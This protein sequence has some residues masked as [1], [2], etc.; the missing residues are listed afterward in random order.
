MTQV[1]S[2]MCTRVKS[3][4]F[5]AKTGNFVAA[6]SQLLHTYI[7]LSRGDRETLACLACDNQKGRFISREEVPAQHSLFQHLEATQRPYHPI[8]TRGYRVGP[9]EGYNEVDAAYENILGLP[10]AAPAELIGNPGMHAATIKGGHVLGGSRTKGHL[11]DLRVARFRV[12]PSY[13]TTVASPRDRWHMPYASQGRYGLLAA[14]EAG[15]QKERERRRHS[16][17]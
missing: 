1:S 7:N 5:V 9:S 16:D 11:R 12:G 8:C 4:N 17:L 6:L 13:R 15:Q 3:G 14:S 2:D 10:V